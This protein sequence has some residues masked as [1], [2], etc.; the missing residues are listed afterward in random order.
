MLVLTCQRK[1]MERLPKKFCDVHLPKQDETI[2]LVDENDQEFNTKFL[3]EKTGLSGGWRGFS[4][5]HKLR[6]GDAL[7]FQLIDRL[8]FKV[9]IVRVHGLNGTDGSLGLV[10]LVPC[11][12][13]AYPLQVEL[14][15]RNLD[16]AEAKDLHQENV[17]DKALVVFDQSGEEYAD[18]DVSEGLRFSQSILEFKD[19]KEEEM[20]IIS[21]KLCGVRE[22][23][24]NLDVEI[25]TLKLKG[26][27]LES[28]F[29][30]EAN[31]PW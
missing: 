12:M 9:Y 22:V 4:I 18:S 31:T 27:N 1:Q 13:N 23:I 26:K 7:V 10:N 30:K 5:A 14:G 29:C 25:E 17:Q 28:V 2:V 24:R 3:V 20:R 16:R 6:E 8:K 15:L 21:K 19:V 11:G